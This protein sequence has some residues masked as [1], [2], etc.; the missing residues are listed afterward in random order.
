MIESEFFYLPHPLLSPPSILGMNFLGRHQTKQLI[1]YFF[2]ICIAQL[3]PYN[4]GKLCTVNTISGLVYTESFTKGGSFATLDG[5]NCTEYKLSAGNDGSSGELV[6][7][8]PLSV[9]KNTYRSLFVSIYV[10]DKPFMYV[11]ACTHKNSQAVK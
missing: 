7:S 4:Q 2:A 3:Y 10:L 6:L 9:F 11:H 8:V 5:V 1:N